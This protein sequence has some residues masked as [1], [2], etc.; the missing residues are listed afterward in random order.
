MALRP[1]AQGD[2]VT[3]DYNTTEYSMA[4]PF[5]CHCGHCSGTEIRGFRHLSI[6]ERQRR[7]RILAAYL[8]PLLDAVAD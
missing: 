8:R 5:L 7:A 4:S 6:P 1:I 2:E 3:Y